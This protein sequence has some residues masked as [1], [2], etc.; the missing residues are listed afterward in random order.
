MNYGE[1][2][3]LVT[4]WLKRSD[5]IPYYPAIQELALER[6]AKDGRL[7]V[8]ETELAITFTD[9]FMSL[10]ADFAAFKRVSG[11]KAG[12]RYPLNLYT[13]QQ[14]DGLTGGSQGESPS[15]YALYSGGM[16]IGPFSADADVS[17]TY[18]ARPPQ[19]VTDADTSPF[20]TKH[21]TIYLYAMLTYAANSMQN[22][23]LEASYGAQYLD[24]MASSNDSDK[25]GQM[26][27]N[28]PMMG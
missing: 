12:R 27:G 14:L 20:L 5:V 24:E 9:A 1:L 6:I 4:F 22:L 3:D 16:E 18:F 25:F 13:K 28:A 2:K 8:Q 7:A 23:E 17:T 15:G 10:P 26:S 11:S 21:P 19:L